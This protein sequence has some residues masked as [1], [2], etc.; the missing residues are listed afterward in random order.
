MSNDSATLSTLSAELTRLRSADPFQVLG[1]AVTIELAPIRTAYLTATKRFHPNRFARESQDV[2]MLSHEVFLLVRRA[3]ESL[4]DPDKRKSIV[5]RLAPSAKPIPAVLPTAPAPPNPR[6]ATAGAPGGAPVPKAPSGPHAP[7]PPAQAPASSTAAPQGAKPKTN[8]PNGPAPAPVP[9][10]ARG[11]TV[12][13]GH[14]PPQTIRPAAGP[15]AQAKSPQEVQAMLEAAR[16]RGQRF[17]D[18]QQL[19]LRGKYKQAREALYEIAAEDPQ[20]KR[21]KVQLHLAWGLE[22]QADGKLEEA[23][24]ELERTLQYEP[25]HS[26][27]QAALRKV[28]EQRKKSGGLLGK[29]FGR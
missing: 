17:D 8:P 5:E 16:T 9:V 23:Q 4:Q 22:H 26:D 7:I 13:G 19:M 10:P 18:A 28:L 1:I 27:A 6:A 24:R 15:A 21:Y 14:S 2:R 29:L 20:S 12:P 3:Y 25:E 11:A